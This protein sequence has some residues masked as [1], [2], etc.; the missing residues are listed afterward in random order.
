M[1]TIELAYLTASTVAIIAMAPQV[2]QL[3]ATKQSDEFSLVSWSIWT[4]SQGVAIGYGISLGALPYII[5]NSIWFSYYL[6]MTGMILYYR[7]P[8]HHRRFT[9]EAE[10][11]S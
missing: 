11:L 10:E 8:R 9:D 4:L 5:V 1:I 7:K 2:K 6:L 3:F